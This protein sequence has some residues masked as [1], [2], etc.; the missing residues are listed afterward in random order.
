MSRLIEIYDKRGTRQFSDS[1][2][3]L[4]IGSDESSQIYL[5]GSLAVEGY[6][7][8]S[9]GFLFL[10][11]AK[12]STPFYHNSQHIEASTWIKSGDTT[13]IGP[14]LLHYAI[15]GARMTDSAMPGP[16]NSR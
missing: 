5:P 15:S 2:L 16:A 14:F 8:E 3:P 1:D 13:R 11:P 12:G 6:I 9:K 7:G 4:A 10:Q